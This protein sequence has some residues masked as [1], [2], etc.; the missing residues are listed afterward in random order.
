VYNGANL[1]AKMQMPAEG[2]FMRPA[3]RVAVLAVLVSAFVAARSEAS[4]ITWESHGTVAYFSD[5]QG[6]FP[7]VGL[8]ST[9]T[10]D[11][12]F[13]PAASPS[14]WPFGGAAACS[15]TASYFTNPYT[16]YLALGGATYTLGGNSIYEVYDPLAN[17]CSSTLVQFIY[18]G[19]LFPFVQV[20]MHFELAATGVLPDSPTG[21]IEL[22]A[23][24]SRLEGQGQ[25]LGFGNLQ[26]VSTPVPEPTPLFLIAPVLAI[27]WRRI[28]IMM[29]TRQANVNGSSA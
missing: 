9:W 4:P 28:R 18:S 14:P 10:F 13:D 21:G 19:L 29:R 25:L 16:A 2:G 22:F 27:G 15:N 17:T 26:T 3:L 23:Q 5:P 20:S 11:F 8:G 12:T 6:H 1:D 24:L 7:G